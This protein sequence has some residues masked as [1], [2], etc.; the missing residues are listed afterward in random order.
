MNSFVLMII[1]YLNSY[2]RSFYLRRNKYFAKKI[3]F[4]EASAFTFMI[5]PARDHKNLKKQFS[6]I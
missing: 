4:Q 6:K 2:H 1:I 5:L 3:L